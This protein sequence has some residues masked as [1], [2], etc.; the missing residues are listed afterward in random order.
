MEK[1]DESHAPLGEPPR[2]QA[3]GGIRSGR[4]RIGAVQ[5]EDRVGL[6]GQI[7][8]L[9]D[10]RLHPKRHLVLGDSRQDLGV[11]ELAVIDRVELAQVVERAAPAPRPRARADSTG[12]EPGRRP[13]ET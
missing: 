11:A 1:L 12:K 9:G 8:Q 5:V 3:V 2:Q 4:A 7:R 6:A 13:S 10:R